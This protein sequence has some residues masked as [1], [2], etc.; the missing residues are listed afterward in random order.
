MKSPRHFVAI[1]NP[2]AGLRRRRRFDAMLAGLHSA[3]WTVDVRETGRRGDA[4]RFAAEAVASQVD[5]VI[6]AGGDGTI[7]EVAN[8][9]L[10]SAIPLAICPLGTANVL[11]AEI[12]LEPSADAVVR[13]LLAGN[14]Q[15]INIGMANDR[16]FLMMAGIG[17]DA[18]VVHGIVPRLKRLL[19]KG[20]YVLESLRQLWRY[21]FPAFTFMIDGVAVTAASGIIA[22][23]HYYGGRFVCAPNARLTDPDFQ[24]CLFMRTGRFNVARYAI[25]MAMGRL[26]ALADVKLMTAKRV[27]VTCVPHDHNAAQPVQGDGDTIGS[28]PVTIRA[29][30]GRLNLI[31]PP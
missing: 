5:G 3:G 30:G 16:A 26:P 10:G 27:Q 13:A 22:N 7:N 4:E 6:A 23:G 18:N 19:G 14:I 29:H 1:Y 24:V 15:R 28:L 31:V 17:F 2:V 25:A 8:G 9:M 20:A 12:G 21:S 11:A